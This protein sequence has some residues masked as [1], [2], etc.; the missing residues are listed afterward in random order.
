VLECFG[1]SG[2][3]VVTDNKVIFKRKGG[4][5][6][7][8]KKGEK[9]LGYNEIIGFQYQNSSLVSPGYIY[10]QLEGDP[11]SISYLMAAGNENAL[12]FTRYTAG[13]F[14]E[15]KPFLDKKIHGDNLNNIFEGRSGTLILADDG[16]V[17][18]RTGA[19][20]GSHTAGEKKIPYRNITAI[21]FKPVN[22]TV[23]FI[24]FT[25]LGG[26]E[27]LGGAFDA[28]SDE[29]TITFG[30]EEK[31]KDFLRAKEIIEQRVR[32]ATNPR[33]QQSGG[34]DLD[35]LE[36]LANLRDKGILTE[37]EFQAKKKQILGL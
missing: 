7:P 2:S 30:S 24:Q 28:T 25:L 11:P 8:H 32:E 14:N 26:R 23:G 36:K 37:D 12:I 4:F 19:L 35:Q 34:S 3:L 31:T 33:P 13:P 1:E 5:L 9:H 27:S 17:L 21:Q 18:K 29:N 6:S 20:I 22:L 16:V 10:F 15:A